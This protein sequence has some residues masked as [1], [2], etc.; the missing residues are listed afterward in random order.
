[1][2]KRAAVFCSPF[3]FVVL[4]TF[5]ALADGRTS[6]CAG[7]GTSRW[8]GG[9]TSCRTRSRTCCGPGRWPSR[10]LHRRLETGSVSWGG[11]NGAL[12]CGPL[13]D[14]RFLLHWHVRP[15]LD[16]FDF[17]N[18]GLK[19]LFA[20]SGPTMSLAMVMPN[21]KAR[22]ADRQSTNSKSCA[23]IFPVQIS[24]CAAPAP[25]G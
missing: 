10:G 15:P 6:R 18:R 13:A 2:H 7:G 21:P 12:Y 14:Q 20:L 22:P 17:L 23:S 19:P 24:Q 8:A 16:F 11:Q 1:M 4:Q 25:I 9:R 3:S 5:L